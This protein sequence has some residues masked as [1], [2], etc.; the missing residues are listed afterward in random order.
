M[1]DLWSVIR[2][3]MDHGAAIQQDYT[4][5][6]YSYEEFQARL[7]DASRELVGELDEWIQAHYVA[8]ANVTLDPELENRLVVRTMN[9]IKQVAHQLSSQQATATTAR[10]GRRSNDFGTSS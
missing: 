7:S 1:S 9:H 5:G 8:P 2:K 4:A 3:L 10:T 6:K